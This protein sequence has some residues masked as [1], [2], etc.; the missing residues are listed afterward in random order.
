MS[1]ASN[2]CCALALTLVAPVLVTMCSS[3]PR[4][5]SGSREGRW[6]ARAAAVDSAGLRPVLR[7]RRARGTERDGVANQ[8]TICI[9]MRDA[10]RPV[11]A[12]R[13]YR[14]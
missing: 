8:M 11:A 10:R 4:V 1:P 3:R 13:D 6:V 2:P 5:V 9:M 7:G 12:A 14:L